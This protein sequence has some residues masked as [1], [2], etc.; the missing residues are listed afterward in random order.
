M[1]IQTLETSPQTCPNQNF[2]KCT[3]AIVGE[4]TNAF[5][6]NKKIFLKKNTKFEFISEF[7]GQREVASR[8]CPDINCHLIPDS[9]Y[10]EV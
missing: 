5:F 1:N 6:P 10:C 4:H 9:K 3:Y 7:Q 8:G 2:K